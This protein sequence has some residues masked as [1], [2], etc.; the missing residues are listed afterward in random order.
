MPSRCAL[1]RNRKPFAIRCPMLDPLSDAVRLVIGGRLTAGS[2]APKLWLLFIHAAAHRK[3]DHNSSVELDQVLKD[4]LTP[5]ISACLHKQSA[6]RKPAKF[7]RRETEIFA[8]APISRLLRRHRRS[9]G[10]RR[11]QHRG[12]LTNIC[13]AKGRRLRSSEGGKQSRRIS[14]GF[15]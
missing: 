11:A 7:D 3:C 9:P 8:S 4:Q 5:A 2:R 6:F 10:K 15:R 14:T 12:V 13:F 1:T